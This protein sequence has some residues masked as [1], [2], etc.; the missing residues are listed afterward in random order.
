MTISL[1]LD[2]SIEVIMS[3][4]LFEGPARPWEEGA[5]VLGRHGGRGQQQASD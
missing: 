1:F 5:S 4:S 2:L 3:H